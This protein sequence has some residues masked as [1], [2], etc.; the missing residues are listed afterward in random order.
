MT[1]SRDTAMPENTETARLKVLIDE[2]ATLLDKFQQ[3]AADSGRHDSSLTHV[4]NLHIDA[5]HK[6]RRVVRI[7]EL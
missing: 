3:L 7:M 5:L 2:H 4:C 1:D 6:A